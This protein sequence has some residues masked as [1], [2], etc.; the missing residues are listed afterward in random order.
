MDP[1]IK[2]LILWTLRVLVPVALTNLGRLFPGFL[3]KLREAS[4]AFKDTC[5]AWDDGQVTS[6]ECDKLFG[7]FRQVALDPEG[8][9][10]QPDLWTALKGP[11]FKM[12]FALLGIVTVI[13]IV[14]EAIFRVLLP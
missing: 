1:V 12:A 8:K 14:A 10:T 3:T 9:P 4:N 7:E 13:W 11:A 6:D 5:A 2:D